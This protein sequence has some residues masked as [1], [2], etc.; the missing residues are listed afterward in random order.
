M[1]VLIAEDETLAAERLQELL[2]QCAPE[3]IV[4][5]QVDSVS[6]AVAF[7]RKAKSIDLLLLDIQLA[8]GK[9][10]EIFE[11][12]DIDV[13]VIFT[14]AYDQYAI[15][16]FK[17]H[18]VDYLLKPIQQDDLRQALSK[19]KK[20]SFPKGSGSIDINALKELLNK[21]SKSY[22][23]RFMIKT[24]NKLQYKP[25]SEISYFFAE[26]KE[27][28]LV[29]KNENR[30][31]LIDHTLE[32][33]ES[34][35]DPREFFRISRKFIIHVDSIRE[36]KGSV[37]T[38]LEVKLNQGCEYDLAVSRDRAQELKAWLDR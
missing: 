1:N 7:L 24:G 33:L 8:D 35:L 11:K 12:I 20:F 21:T 26:G 17:F 2:Q 18:S 27:A 19:L 28:Y 31:F 37:S 15:H 23:E 22:K 3:A 10:F 38:R 25:T 13:P 34:L 9:S 36:I 6:E 5:D 16:A 14:T 32:D 30:K 4:L 29:T